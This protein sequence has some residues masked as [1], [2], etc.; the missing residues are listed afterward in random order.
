MNDQL[1]S[2]ISQAAS[3]FLGA[4]ITVLVG[5]KL[6]QPFG[7]LSLLAAAIWPIAFYWFGRKPGRK[8]V[9]EEIEY[10]DKLH[11][12]VPQLINDGDYYRRLN[13]Q[14]VLDGLSSRQVDQ[15]RSS[16][17]AVVGEAQIG[18]KS[19]ADKAKTFVV[20]VCWVIIFLFPTA[21][22]AA[23]AL[24]I[25]GVMTG[26]LG[27][28]LGSRL[29]LLLVVF[30]VS[31]AACLIARQLPMPTV[32]DFLI[33]I[34]GGALLWGMGYLTAFLALRTISIRPFLFSV[35]LSLFGMS[36]AE[37]L[38][39]RRSIDES[40]RHRFELLTLFMGMTFYYAGVIVYGWLFVEP[41]DLSSAQAI[42][43]VCLVGL[44]GLLCVW[45]CSRQWDLVLDVVVDS[46]G[47]AA[48]RGV[49]TDGVDKLAQKARASMS[50]IVGFLPA[51]ALFSLVMGICTVMGA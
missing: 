34:F 21:H 28:A 18:D 11:N 26:S 20:V 17:S 44:S 38:P 25:A 19:K 4:V 15:S 32:Y 41:V 39:Y 35:S 13:R 8:E 27:A 42:L 23:W 36:F 24:C 9:L 47:D 43:L 6:P 14:L 49:L 3:G 45:L 46:C 10:L 29:S 37:Y 50:S 40:I 30:A 2:M 5:A 51:F 48:Q 1:K 31:V 7:V 22:G 12:H 16:S 33:Y